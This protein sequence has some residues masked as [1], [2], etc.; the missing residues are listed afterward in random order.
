MATLRDS[1]E[2]FGHCP[3]GDEC[4]DHC[5]LEHECKEDVKQSMRLA[6]FEGTLEDKSEVTEEWVKEHLAN[7]ADRAGY[8]LVPKT[9]EAWPLKIRRVIR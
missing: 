5:E 2:C 3:D 1:K 6:W 4:F 8:T 7:L 9:P